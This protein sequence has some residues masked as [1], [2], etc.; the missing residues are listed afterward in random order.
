MALRVPW[1]KY[2][3]IILL[4][5]WLQIKSGVPKMQMVNLVSYQLRLKAVNQ[6]LEIDDIF[7]NT[8]G[9]SF[10]LTSMATAYE[11]MDM[12]KPASKLFTE[13]VELYLADP[14][15][16]QNMKEEA[17]QM[18]AYSSA[19]KDD[20]AR[21]VYVT[22]PQLAT[23][24]LE[25]IGF[26][27]N[28]AISTKALSH[29]IFENLTDETITI[30]KRKVLNHKFFIV[31]YKKYLSLAELGLQLLADYIRELPDGK[32]DMIKNEKTANT[33]IKTNDIHNEDIDFVS[34]MLQSARLRSATARSYKS[35]INTCDLYARTNGLYSGSI[36]A[37]TTYDDFYEMYSLLMNDS[38][39][40]KTSEE[41][42]N[43]LVAALYKYRDY[44][45]SFSVVSDSAQQTVTPAPVTDEY[46]QKYVAILIQE[47]EDGYCI[48]DYMHRMRFQS[49][50]EERYGYPTNLDMDEVESCLESIGQVRDNRIFYSD[51]SDDSLLSSI[52][53]DIKNAFDN[54]ATA[55]YYECLYDRYSD[56][57][58]SEMSIY[59]ADTLRTVIQSDGNF[60]KEYHAMKSYI[61]KYGV[62]ADSNE[63]IRRV[64]QSFHVPVTFEE[65]QAQVPHIPMY[66]IKQALMQIDDA[67]YVDEGTY[68]YA[69]NFY[70]PSEEKIALI[71]AIRSAISDRGFLVA[72]ELREVFRSVCPS[73]AMD[74][75]YL[76]DHGIRNI[77]KV[78]LR[79][80]FEFSLSVITN[81]GEQLDYGQVFQNYAADR[82]RLTLSEL[83]EL[84]KE[85]GLPA[86]YWDSIFKEMIRISETELVRKSTVVF[87]VTAVDK[88]LEE[89]YPDEYTPLKDITLFLSLPPASVR[90]NGFLLESFLREYSE[91]FRLVQLSVSQD[92][93]FGVML[94]RSSDL[95]NYNDVSADMLARNH[96]WSDEKSALQLLKAMNFQ[97]RAKN[98]NISAII[99][100]A[101]Q[102]RLN[103]D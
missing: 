101:K 91:K 26:M 37:C 95:E 32:T 51:N 13:I 82:K 14:S 88:T 97:Q 56:R 8:N 33:I 41:K 2:E 28:F 15:A 48:G 38:G 3:A 102:K 62:E 75:E 54:G 84:K 76:K 87:D 98:S 93:Y 23:K 36:F 19:T 45:L 103:I 55:V 96:S 67:A 81:K 90:W 12:G 50:Y 60:P 61:I 18:V 30:L 86:I 25:S 40:R 70:I 34:W 63:E 11:K 21:Y 24:I 99:K 31:K 59:S 27:E 49:A 57:L 29:S 71:H 43:Y 79:D 46:T 65:L 47:F 10:Q 9:I 64:L 83:L 44:M 66:R 72:K 89:M 78:L 22:Q 92:D 68:F 42:H 4:E 73:S 74:S 7:R 35:A 53:K 39:F 1:D 20:F 6:G 5:A 80:E 52:Y 85:L 77:L 16:Y 94:K 100:V 17:L 58:A 69:P